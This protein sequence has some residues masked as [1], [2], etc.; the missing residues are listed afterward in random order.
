MTK[1]IIKAWHTS[2]EHARSEDLQDADK[3]TFSNN[4]MREYGWLCVG[5][6]EIT[7]RINVTEED[8][9]LSMCDT[10]RQQIQKV[11]A[12]SK[13]QIDDLQERINKLLALTYSKGGDK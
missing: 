5:E 6:A 4:D 2:P 3:L 11:R 8:L 7:L 12:E 1:Q 10:L 13:K 9:A